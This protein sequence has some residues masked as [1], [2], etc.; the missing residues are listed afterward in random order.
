M[1]SVKM[2]GKG[3]ASWNDGGSYGFGSVLMEGGAVRGMGV[4]VI[5]TVKSERP[6]HRSVTWVKNSEC[7]L[8]DDCCLYKILHIQSSNMVTPGREGV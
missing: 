8:V 5:T 2:M 3:A 6:R 7:I 1:V 4:V